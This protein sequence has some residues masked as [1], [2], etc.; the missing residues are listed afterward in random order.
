MRVSFQFQPEST[1]LEERSRVLTMGPG[2]SVPRSIQELLQPPEQPTR[3]SNVHARGPRVRRA[4]TNV[5][6]P[7][8]ARGGAAA[9]GVSAPA[10][11]GVGA[12]AAV[13]RAGCT[14]ENPP[15]L[16]T[17][18]SCSLDGAT[19]LI[20][21]ARQGH[22][23]IVKMLIEAGANQSLTT[24]A[25][26]TALRVAACAQQHECVKLLIP[27]WL[28]EQRL[29]LVSLKLLVDQRRAGPTEGEQSRLLARVLDLHLETGILF[30]VAAYWL[31][32]AYM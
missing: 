3:G 18:S 15:R 9:A 21:A 4:V 17:L 13:G 14:P 23:E 29:R 10:P 1:R 26:D 11:P 6:R 16:V 31:D 19:A 7:E 32:P 30:R 25:G 27:P 5:V 22:A 12:P 2:A 20:A 28:G 8:P 24:R